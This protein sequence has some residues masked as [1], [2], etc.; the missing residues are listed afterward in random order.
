MRA[1]FV[2]AVSLLLVVPMPAVLAADT[3]PFSVEDLVR[4]RRISDPQVSPDGNQVA[5][6]LR[7]TDMEADK[8]RKDLW[9]VGSGGASPRQLTTHEANDSHPRWSADGRHLYFLSSRSGTTQ[10]WRLPLAGGEAQPVTTLELDV[11]AFAVSPVGDRLVM[12]IDVFRDCEDLKCTR[13]RLDETE[14]DKVSGQQYARLKFRHWDEWKD[15]RRSVL[16]SMALDEAGI[17]SGG[18]VGLTAA[19]D[20]DVP[21]KPFGGSEDFSF[22][23][24]GRY[25]YFESK[26]AGSEEA[27][28]TN[29]DIYRVM[30]DGS[31]EPENLTA[32]NL[33]WDADPQLSPDG[34]TLAYLAMARPGFEAD[35][36]RIVLLDLESNHRW[37]LTQAWDRSVSAF[38]WGERGRAIYATAMDTGAKPLW[39]ID[40]RNGKPRELAGDGNVTALA[41]GGNRIVFAR[42]DLRSPVDL[43][44]IRDNGRE[45]RP[46]TDINAEAMAATQTG[47]YEQFSFAGWNDET[48]HGYAVK[49]ANFER[50]GKYPV[51]FLIHGGPQGSFSNQ[52]HY[53]W[54][55]QTYAGAGFAVVTIDFHGSTGYGQAF[56]DAIR[57]DWGGKPLEDLQRGLAA[58]V[59]RYP[60]LDGDRVCALGGS[61]G[62]YMIN[63]IAGNWPDGFRCL[64]NH[65][66]ILD[67]RMMYYAT[68]ELWFPEWEHGG[69]HFA[70]PENYEKHNPV[71]H[72]DRWRTPMLVIHGALDYRV[73]DTQG[74]GTFNALQRRGIPSE[75]LY[76]PDENHWVLKPHNSI[77]WHDTVNGWL[78]RWL[79]ADN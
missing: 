51:A 44:S 28:S 45:L 36:F 67:N 59:E 30:A 43:Y 29:F 54:N 37:A 27:W 42:S 69:P 46:L 10:V 38:A 20:G 47:V 24:D 23:P 13:E 41:V 65:D 31:G 77:R 12:S 21:A 78:G 63:W 64:V 68:E 2:A 61:Y 79:G 52:F 71:N 58:A 50:G 40:V 35:R 73:P 1:G 11:N 32:E 33:A 6:V 74:I 9:L 17:A 22:S 4:L 55:P 48:V 70:A 5:F 57:N 15:G 8:G 7:E 14:A 62:G 76:F 34:K 3:H 60:W 66:G 56:T 53:R 19:L 72:V 16:F 75:F 39:R 25:V 49:P 26:D 18:P